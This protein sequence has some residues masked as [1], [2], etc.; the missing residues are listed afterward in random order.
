M[1]RIVSPEILD[2]LAPA[3]PRAA[4]SRRD[5]VQVNRLMNH[6]GIVSRHLRATH[7]GPGARSLVDLG[8]GDGMFLLRVAQKLGPAWRG[9]RATL[10]DRQPVVSEATRREFAH[11]GWSVEVLEAEVLE[12]LEKTS[13][14]HEL[15]VANLFL[16]HFENDALVKLLA[17]ASGRCRHFVAC[18]PRRAGLAL[19]AAKL[20]WVVGCNAVTQHDAVVSV[21]AGFGE[22]ELSSRWPERERWELRERRAGLFSHFFAARRTA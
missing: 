7:L 13:G 20:L 3:D 18:E 10:L 17:R 16:H 1:K 14:S 22:E 11:L 4:H 6:V 5:L 21:H 9:V 2:R 15:M 12:W 8:T 19:A